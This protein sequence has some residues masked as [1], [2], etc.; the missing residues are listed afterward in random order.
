MPDGRACNLTTPWTYA[1]GDE[2]AWWGGLWADRTVESDFAASAIAGG[3]ATPADLARIA[4]GWRAWAADQDGW[5][6][7]PN[8]EIRCRAG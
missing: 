5:F 3:H 7:V 4:G 8:G 1:T 2:R 6:L